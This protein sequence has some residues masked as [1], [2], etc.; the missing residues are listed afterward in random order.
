MRDVNSTEQFR[1]GFVAIGGRTNVGKSTLLNRLV[2]HKVAIVTPLPQTTRRRIVGIRHDPDAQLILIDMPGLHAPHKLLNQRMVAVARRALGEG[3]VAVGVIE[4]GARL[5]GGDRAF[6]EE[7]RTV[8]VGKI[9]AINKI[10]QMGRNQILPLIEE[11]RALIAE[12]EI[13][14]ISALTGENVDDLVQT[15]KRMLPVG[16]ALMPAD[17]YTDQSER[18]LVEELIREQIF[19]AMHQ[20]IPFSTAVQVEQFVEEPERRM[21]RI[22]ALVIVE[23]DSHKGMIIGAGGRQLKKIGTAARLGIEALLGTRV[24]LELV[25]KVEK[26]WTRN[27]RKLAE[28]GL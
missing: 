12:A 15:I 5:R 26:D 14:P 16:P 24:F 20:E 21:V 28:L 19:L 8:K 10:D 27:P 25:V 23:R 13:V 6:L 9:V 1:S 7:L 3:E 18:G 2:G 11:C 22:V 17:E 4:A